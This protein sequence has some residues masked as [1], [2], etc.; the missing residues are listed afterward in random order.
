MFGHVLSS[1]MSLP[2]DHNLA[3]GGSKRILFAHRQDC[4]LSLLPGLAHPC[5]RV[6]GVSVVPLQ[7]LHHVLV[8]FALVGNG[9]GMNH[10]RGQFLA[11]VLGVLLVFRF[12][13]S[14]SFAE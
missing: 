14:V 1:Q 6:G 11:F 3:V 2:G 9:I 10:V 13:Y 5:G 12:R 8:L 7:N 4:R